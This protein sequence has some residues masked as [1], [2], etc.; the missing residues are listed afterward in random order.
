MINLQNYSFPF[1]TCE[2]CDEEGIVQP[3]SATVNVLTCLMIVSFLVQTRT[4]HAFILLTTIVVFEA[5]HACSHMIHMQGSIQSTVTHT[6]AYTM[7][8]AF[9]W[10]FYQ[11]TGK[12]PSMLFVFYMILVIGIDMYCFLN[13]S[14]VEYLFTSSLIF[15]SLL[16]YYYPALPVK[17][18]D[19]IPNIVAIICVIIALFVNEMLNCAAWMEWNPHIPYHVVIEGMGALLFYTICRA[20]YT[21]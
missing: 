19:S 18:H 17:V 21:L 16:A 7:N 10:A 12:R 11:S 13:R 2:K 1:S 3:Y 8:I 9:A 15:V 4:L 6:L 5:F 14:F 20:V